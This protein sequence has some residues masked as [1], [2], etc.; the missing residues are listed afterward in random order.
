MRRRRIVSLVIAIGMGSALAFVTQ[1]LIVELVGRWEVQRA[2]D[3]LRLPAGW[4]QMDP[5]LVQVPHRGFVLL[6][7]VYKRS[8]D[9]F[10]NLTDFLDVEEREGWQPVG[11]ASDFS[12]VELQ[13]N[14]LMLGAAVIQGAGVVRIELSRSVNTWW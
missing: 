9:V 1:P 5:L 2:R 12:T 4:S 3:A 8:G 13:M 11:G 6:S 7:V 10:A 14:D